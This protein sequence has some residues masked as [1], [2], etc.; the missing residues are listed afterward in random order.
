MAK[1]VR[2][3]KTKQNALQFIAT[4]RKRFPCIQYG[5][6]YMAGGHYHAMLTGDISPEVAEQLK[7]RRDTGFTFIP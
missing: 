3:F 6:S 4:A 1:V 2:F 7:G 5:T